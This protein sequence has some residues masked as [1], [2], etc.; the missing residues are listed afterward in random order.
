[1]W[2]AN[3]PSFFMEVKMGLIVA[4]MVGDYL[5][6]NRWMAL[7]KQKNIWICSLHALIYAISIMVIC[8]WYDWRIAVVFISHLII[9]H[10][11]IGGIWRKFYSRDNELPWIITA[12]NT[13]HLIILWLL[14]R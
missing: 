1:M 11:C 5:F 9:D 10:W 12:D 8:G 3:K 6:Q 13:M 2:K 7:N 14:S 4:H